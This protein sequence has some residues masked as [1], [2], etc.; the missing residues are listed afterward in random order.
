MKLKKLTVLTFMLASVLG[1]TNAPD[2]NLNVGNE[3]PVTFNVSTLSV[4][5][6]PMSRGTN[7]GAE[8]F[9]VIHSVGYYIYDSNSQL[10]RS[11]GISFDPETELVPENFG[12]FKETMQ[13][14][15]YKVLFYGIG[16]GDGNAYWENMDSYSSDMMLHFDNNEFFYYCQNLTI[17]PSSTM[18]EVALSRKSALLVIDIKDEVREDVSKVEYLFSRPTVWN[19]YFEET[20]KSNSL[21]YEAVKDGNKLKQFEYYFPFPSENIN[22]TINIYDLSSNILGS[23]T[24]LV[25]LEANRKTIVTGELFSSLGDKELTI[26]LDDIWEEDWI[27]EF[28]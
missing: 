10:Y 11:G 26:V 19:P 13:P 1:C 28:Q 6:Q 17:A 7:S 16:K 24:M 9:E 3:I 23:K 15:E 8:I 25:P 5:T 14:G 2:S 20:S 18:I 21:K 12:L 22:L 4:E 27:Y